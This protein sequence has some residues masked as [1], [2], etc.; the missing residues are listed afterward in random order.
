MYRIAL[1]ERTT[2]P[3][4]MRT[5]LSTL[6]VPLGCPDALLQAQGSVP[7]ATRPTLNPSTSPPVS[8]HRMFYLLPME[9]PL[10]TLM[11]RNCTS[12]HLPQAF[13]L[14]KPAST[15]SNIPLSQRS[16]PYSIQP[17]GRNTHECKEGQRFHTT[18]TCYA[19]GHVRANSYPC[20]AAQRPQQ[21][22]T[23][24]DGPR[25][26]TPEILR[27]RPCCLAA[28]RSAGSSSLSFSKLQRVASRGHPPP[29][30]T[31]WKYSLTKR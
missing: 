26:A 1:Y 19:E 15:A 13:H 16:T 18:W 10:E 6:T 3:P 25:M 5:E 21:V 7:V 27:H 30:L 24:T 31:N 11:T 9:P 22:A 14:A 29:T 8:Y 23:A 12:H 2:L 4:I 17:R 20:P 28:R